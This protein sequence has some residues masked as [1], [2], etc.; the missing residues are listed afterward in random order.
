MRAIILAAG[1]GGRLFPLTAD[2]PKALLDLHGR[3]ILEHQMALLERTG[4]DDLIIVTGY[5][6]QKIHEAAGKSARFVYNADYQTTNSLYSLWTAR[7][8]LNQACLV[9]NSDVLF[10]PGIVERLLAD[11]APDALA[12]DFRG[13]LGEEEMKVQTR[14]GVIVRISKD[15]PPAEAEGENT[16]IVKLSVEGAKAVIGV[17]EECRARGELRHWVPYAVGTLVGR[18]PF[19]AVDITGLPWIEIDYRH[20]LERAR[21]EVLPQILAAL[22]EGS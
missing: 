6:A 17:A 13:G 4:V 9:L 3:S 7:A 19:K 21:R 20:D 14:Q 12:I 15:M 22:R 18:R 10:H 8:Y 2:R 16:G 5:E 1:Q 11:A